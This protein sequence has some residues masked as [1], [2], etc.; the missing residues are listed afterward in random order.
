MFM[1]TTTTQSGKSLAGFIIGLLLATMV[2]VGV[3]F[4]LNK[5]KTT[6]KQPEVQ[7][8]TPS[9]PE[10]LR[11][12]D[13]ASN[14]TDTNGTAQS[15]SA[16]P[17]ENAPGNAAPATPTPVPEPA[18]APAH[19]AKTQAKPQTAGKPTKPAHQPGKPTPAEKSK[20]APQNSVHPED[21]LNSG[22]LEKAEQKAQQRARNTT[23]PDTG[24]KKV[25]LQIGSYYDQA[26][27]D[28]QRAKLAMLGVDALIRKASVN[29][30]TM[31]RVQTSAISHN[32]AQQLSNK[33]KQNK[34][35]SLMRTAP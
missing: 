10:I 2:I 5:N 13:A 28:A 1:K 32:Q 7:N 19:P 29:G 31:Y 14:P 9:Q 17:A 22:S 18:T 20:T 33:L 27:A 21:I 25:V 6:F 16:V 23:P 15:A 12:T 30:K 35:D 3:L 26:S 8:N 4:F 11:P 34:I 24:N